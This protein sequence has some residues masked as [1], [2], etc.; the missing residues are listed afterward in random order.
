MGRL[1]R[2]ARKAMQPMRRPL[3][4][5]ASGP[6]RFATRGRVLA[7]KRPGLI[8]RMFRPKIRLSRAGRFAEEQ[9][10]TQPSA[11]SQLS[12]EDKA[13]ITEAAEKEAA[14]QLTNEYYGAEKVSLAGAKWKDQEI[15]QDKKMPLQSE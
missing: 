9:A 3:A 6:K 11:F 2:T 4:R 8:G 1:R 5:A 12:A 14:V 10:Q 15:V 13:R 7:R